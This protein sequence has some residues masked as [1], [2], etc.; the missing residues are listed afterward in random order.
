LCRP[1]EWGLEG[2]RPHDFQP[3][4]QALRGLQSHPQVLRHIMGVWPA[5][6]MFVAMGGES[7]FCMAAPR[8]EFKEVACLVLENHRGVTS[9]EGW[10]R[11]TI[12]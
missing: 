8:G 2:D 3:E 11:K 1:P 12:D 10:I 7:S 5:R 9:A 6:S 4:A